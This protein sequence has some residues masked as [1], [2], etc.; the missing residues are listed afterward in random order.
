[1]NALSLSL[2]LI[3][4]H[5]LLYLTEFLLSAVAFISSRLYG[6]ILCKVPL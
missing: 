1:M 2:Q 6:T 4:G 5:E 3:Y